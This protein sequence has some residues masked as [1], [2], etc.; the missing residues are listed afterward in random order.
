MI[1]LRLRTLYRR[2]KGPQHPLGR[3]LEAGCCSCR[4]SKPFSLQS[5][6]QSVVLLLK[7][8]SSNSV[9]VHPVEKCFMKCYTYNYMIQTQS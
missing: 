8:M 6:S 3:R 7:R 4:K 2:G 1:G 9:K 5:V